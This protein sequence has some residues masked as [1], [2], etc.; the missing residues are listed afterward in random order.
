MKLPIK[1]SKQSR[2]PYYHQIEEQIKALIAS[3]QL[4]ANAPLPSIRALSKDLE[5]SVITTRRAFQNLEYEG[6]IYTTQGKGTFV[7]EINQGTMQQVQHDTVRKAINK[8]IETAKQHNY[9]HDDI[10][11]IVHEI[12]GEKEDLS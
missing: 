11:T 12:L 3:G 7:A 9:T 6:F 5:V 2:E 1:L 8:A 10:K 4:I